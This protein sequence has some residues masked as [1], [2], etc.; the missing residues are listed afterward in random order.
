[1][2]FVRA[3]SPAIHIFAGENVCIQ[4]ISPTQFAVALADLHRSRIAS[5]VVSTGL[6]RTF[7]GSDPAESRDR[8]ISTDAQLV[9]ASASAMRAVV[10]PELSGGFKVRLEDGSVTLQYENR[11]E[12][13]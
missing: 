10:T 3:D 4:A 2:G 8:A 6:N 12:R 13:R 7:T 11:G 9:T 1:M 5:G